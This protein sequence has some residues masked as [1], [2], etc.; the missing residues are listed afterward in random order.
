MSEMAVELLA[1]D[2][3][4]VHWGRTVDVVILHLVN[5]SYTPFFSE[6]ALKASIRSVFKHVPW[7]SGKLFVVTD[8]YD[9][10]STQ[11]RLDEAERVGCFSG[12]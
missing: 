4:L 6:N 10:V 1:D 7:A 8:V 11:F 12:I 5:G 2:G 9:D 3:G